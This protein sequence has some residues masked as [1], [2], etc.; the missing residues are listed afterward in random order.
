MT[1]ADRPGNRDRRTVAKAHEPIALLAALVRIDSTSGT[2]GERMVLHRVARWLAD[3][4]VP[5]VQVADGTC[6]P[7]LFAQSV[8][9]AGG[10]L[11]LA[12]H[13][14]TVP[15]TEPTQWRYGPFDA[16]VHGDDLY[17]RGASDMKGGIA[18]AA[19]ALAHLA[20]LRIP[21]ALVVTVGEEIGCVGARGAL[22]RVRRWQPSAVIVPEATSGQI[23]LGHR[24]AVWLDVAA[25]G[26][27]AHGAQPQAGH[28]AILALAQ[29]VLR[30]NH[31]P[32]KEHP[33]LGKETVNVGVIR[34]GVKPNMVPDQC[35]ATLDVRIVGTDA[36]HIVRWL[37]TLPDIVSVTAQMS[38]PAVWTPPTHPWVNQVNPIESGADLTVPYFTDASVLC[39]ALEPGVPVVVWGP[40]DV[41]TM[42]CVDERVELARVRAA[43]DDYVAAA[44]V[45]SS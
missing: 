35:V 21:A 38:L 22:E 5:H 24:G 27:A 40:G 25:S 13:A 39:A 7:Y 1:N 31:A 9:G 20:R 32:I 10:G 36:D 8:D 14:D 23:K 29:A 26:V 33:L 44:R 16:V 41:S 4:G 30:L 28:N 3:H 2:P 37:L 17:G 6:G 43:V 11:L 18:A 19:A 42:H 45:S 12:T 15:V 34:G